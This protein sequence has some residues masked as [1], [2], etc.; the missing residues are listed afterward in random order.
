MAMNDNEGFIREVNEELRSD[1]LK[2]VWRRFGPLI[3]ALAVLIVVGTA[4]TRGYQYWQD[5]QASASGDRFLSAL[6]DIEENRKDEA[7]KTLQALEKDGFGSYPLLASMR[8]ATL[9]A[10]KGDIAAAVA[11]FSEIGKDTSVPEALRN[12]AKLRAA[13]LLVDNGTY[14]QVSAEVESL[15]VP[16]AAMRHSARETLGLAAYKAGD[17]VKARDWFQLIADDAEAPGNVSNRAHMMLDLITASGKA[18]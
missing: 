16:T 18:S 8:L 11:G 3:I 12:A 9:Q 15:A 13:Y 4:G 6:K 5:S 7:E 10:E 17:L 2:A 14:E 1:Q